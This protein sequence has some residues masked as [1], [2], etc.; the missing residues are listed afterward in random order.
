MNAL[1]IALLMGSF[2]LLFFGGL[3]AVPSRRT[4]RKEHGLRP[5]TPGPEVTDAERSR[6]EAL[7]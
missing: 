3:Y 4:W 6:S 7:V 2:L 5:E 1:L